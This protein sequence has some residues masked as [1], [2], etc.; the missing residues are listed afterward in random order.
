ML[1]GSDANGRLGGAAAPG[2]PAVVALSVAALAL[3]AVV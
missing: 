1:R 3:A 2:A